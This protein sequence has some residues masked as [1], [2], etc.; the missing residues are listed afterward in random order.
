VTVDAGVEAGA[1]E[2]RPTRERVWGAVG[3]VGELLI[4]LGVVLLLLVA[5]QLWWTN[6]E[7][8][9]AADQSVA[10]LQEAWTRPPAPAPADPD[11][12]G[13]PDG[14]A[15]P[16]G[17]VKPEFGSAF[18]LMYVPRLRDRVWGAPIVHGVGDYELARGIGHYPTAALPG[19][20]GNF[21]VA[22]HRATN[23]EPFRDIDR[24]T[25]G[26]EVYVETRDTWYVYRL[27]R[28]QIVTPD[29]TWVIGPVPGQPGATPSESLITLT[30]CH[31]RWA[32][33]ERW[34][35]WGSLV[36]TVDKADGETPDVILGG[37]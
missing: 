8:S 29:A 24:L 13:D 23:G 18:A 6:V 36:E 11:V 17:Y 21:A 33:Y 2:R 27:E 28:D 9:R 5:Y 34:I 32:S 3:V 10:E 22:G 4:T 31:P 37:R 12:P 1:G 19:E 14:S 15:E 7:A 35:W 25:V 26:D 20:V 30:T 16:G